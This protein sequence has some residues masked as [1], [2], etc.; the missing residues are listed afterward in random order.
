[1]FGHSGARPSAPV[2]IKKGNPGKGRRIVQKVGHKDL[3][4]YTPEQPDPYPQPLKRR[5]FHKE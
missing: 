1:V 5:R 3:N 2:T 4:T